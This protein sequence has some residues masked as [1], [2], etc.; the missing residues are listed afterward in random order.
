MAALLVQRVGV[1]VVQQLDEAGDVA[2]RSAQVVGDRIAE[3]FQF[4]VGGLE[5]PDIILQ[6]L[7]QFADPVF[8]PAGG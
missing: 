4:L 8:S 1:A 5:L 3:G 6:R 7:V 2:Q